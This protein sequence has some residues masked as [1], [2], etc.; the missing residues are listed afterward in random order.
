V[1]PV[2][3]LGFGWRSASRAA[4]HAGESVKA[5]AAEV[6][7]SSSSAVPQRAGKAGL[8]PLRPRSPAES[9][10]AAAKRENDRQPNAQKTLEARFVPASSTHD[11]NEAVAPQAIFV[12]MQTA[13]YDESGPTVWSICVWRVTVVDSTR[14]RI[15]A[16][17]I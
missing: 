7:K 9:S 17:K 3:K 11:E 14:T 6:A 13:R 1:P 4:V 8:Q 5:L 15:P 16:K 12:I 10:F 2:K